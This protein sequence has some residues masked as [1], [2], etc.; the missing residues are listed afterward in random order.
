MKATFTIDNG[1]FEVSIT[2]KGTSYQAKGT[3]VLDEDAADLR[4]SIEKLT[5]YI[6]T[7]SSNYTQS[8][9]TLNK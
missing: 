6:I 5:A 3:I 4:G 9:S 2:S 8:K 7:K 1:Q